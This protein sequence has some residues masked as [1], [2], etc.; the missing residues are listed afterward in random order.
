MTQDGAS[1]LVCMLHIHR[2]LSSARS[3]LELAAGPFHNPSTAAEGAMICGIDVSRWTW[4]GMGWHDEA[5][6]C[7][8]VCYMQHPMKRRL[9]CSLS[10]HVSPHLMLAPGMLMQGHE[11][12]P[13]STSN[14][15]GSLGERA[16]PHSATR[17]RL[18]Q[19]KAV[20]A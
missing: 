5:W 13:G 17:V 15:Q 3:Q 10:K 6:L 9:A 8:A 12:K 16:Q 11:H 1:Q 14:I 18:T 4:A 7:L 2:Q 19:Q 20:G